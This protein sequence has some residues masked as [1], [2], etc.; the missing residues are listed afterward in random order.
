MIIQ[1]KNKETGIDIEDGLMEIEDDIMLE[2]FV[3]ASEADLIFSNWFNKILK[4][5]IHKQNKL[6]LTDED[7]KKMKD[8]N[9]LYPLRKDKKK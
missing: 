9:T 5:Y 6:I 8:A 4:N 2:C 3:I 1:L 7:Y